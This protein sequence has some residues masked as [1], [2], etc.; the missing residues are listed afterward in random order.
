MSHITF[1]CVAGGSIYERAFAGDVTYKSVIDLLKFVKPKKWW[2][3]E[4]R[5]ISHQARY[6]NI[7]F[8]QSDLN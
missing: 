5:D 3:C 7:D 8:K 2:N 4:V 6:R 1:A